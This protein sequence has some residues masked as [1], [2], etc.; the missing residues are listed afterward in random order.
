MD[1]ETALRNQIEAKSKQSAGDQRI[2]DIL[3]SKPSRRRDRQL[4]RM[5]RHAAAAAQLSGDPSTIDWSTVDWSKL[6]ETI[7]TVLLKLLPLLLA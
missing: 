3:D 6:L 5:A 1:F 2:M 7:M 4:D